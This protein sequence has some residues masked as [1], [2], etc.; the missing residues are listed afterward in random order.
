MFTNNRSETIAPVKGDDKVRDINKELAELGAIKAELES[1]IKEGKSLAAEYYGLDEKVAEKDIELQKLNIEI[2]EAK[3][4]VEDVERLQEKDAELR[5][6]IEKLQKEIGGLLED[7]VSISRDI[8]DLNNS[9]STKEAELNSA[10]LALES[11]L[12]KANKEYNQFEKELEKMVNEHTNS[13]FDKKTE[14]D[15]LISELSDAE[16]DLNSLNTKRAKLNSDLEGLNIAIKETAD[17]LTQ[18][19]AKADAKYNE[20]MAEFEEYKNAETLKIQ[21][22]DGELSDKAKFLDVRENFLRDV[23]SQLED[24]LGKKINNMNF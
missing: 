21:E 4:K 2:K 19:T 23:K 14:L 13:L 3:I 8:T 9:K 22:R 5:E 7:R 11:K 18:E 12:Y 10:I 17:K 24:K 1:E 16:K 6:I 20:R 15:K